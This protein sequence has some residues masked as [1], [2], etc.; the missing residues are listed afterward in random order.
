MGMHEG[1]FSPEHERP[2]IEGATEVFPG[3]WRL[4]KS[5][6]VLDVPESW[7]FFDGQGLLVLDPGGELPIA[8]RD[9]EVSLKPLVAQLTRSQENRKLAAV[10]ALEAHYGVPV[11]GILLTHGD[12]DHTNNIENISAEPIPIYVGKKGWWST[13]SPET[14]F[15]AGKVMMQKSPHTGGTPGTLSGDAGDLVFRDIGFQAFAEAMNNPRGGRMRHEKKQAL[16]ARFQEYPESFALPDTKLEVVPLPGHAPEEVGF[17]IPDQ[18]IFIGGDL[19]VTSK[20]EQSQRLNLFLPEANVFSA[21]ASLQRL[22]QMDIEQYYPA[23]GDVVTG[24]EAIQSWIDALATDAKRIIDRTQAEHRQHPHATVRQLRP[25]VFTNDLRRAGMSP[26]SEE[27]WIL[28][29]LR[30]GETQADVAAG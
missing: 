4:T 16:A 2:T 28:S 11:K 19:L 25:L 1:R 21:L 30:D 23:H 10:K 15:A 3:G 18:R 27:T 24:R 14:Q 7:V 29:V 22:R 26:R 13:L 9:D 8:S 12:A 20:V 17:Y 6:T 5:E